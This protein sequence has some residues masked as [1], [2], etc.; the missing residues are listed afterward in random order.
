M[1][2]S[3]EQLEAELERVITQARQFITDKWST[4]IK[5][6]SYI[7]ITSDV[8][9]ALELVRDYRDKRT[10]QSHY[11][12]TVVLK[13]LRG[14]LYDAIEDMDP[15]DQWFMSEAERVPVRTYLERAIKLTN[16]I[17]DVLDKVITSTGEVPDHTSDKDIRDA[18]KGRD[19]LS[20]YILYGFLALAAWYYFTKVLPNQKK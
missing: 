9:T 19:Q 11:T 17:I 14:T 8:D 10:T 1:S 15:I 16:K 5:I 4:F 20:N 2:Y 6:N 12:R 3:T 13:G 18:E 7:S